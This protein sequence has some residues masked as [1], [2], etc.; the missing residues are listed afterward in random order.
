MNLL[1]REPV[2]GEDARRAVKVNLLFGDI[3]D[4]KR[5]KNV[6][7]YS[8]LDSAWVSDLDQAPSS[9]FNPFA[10]SN[11]R[12][13]EEPRNKVE[14]YE[15]LTEEQIEKQNQKSDL[16]KEVPK[17]QQIKRKEKRKLMQ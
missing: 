5:H 3:F 4:N 12:E 17:S 16:I 10:M 15:D 11:R 14:N 1:F 9:V 7:R 2:Y 8:K 13:E 6:D